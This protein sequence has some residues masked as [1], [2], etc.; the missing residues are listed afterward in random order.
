MYDIFTIIFFRDLGV[1]ERTV[2]GYKC[3]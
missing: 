2:N 3:D 1:F